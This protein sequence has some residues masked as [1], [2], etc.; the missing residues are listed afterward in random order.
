MIFSL[1]NAKD[2]NPLHFRPLAVLARVSN[3][4]TCFETQLLSNHN[5]HTP[6]QIPLN[7]IPFGVGRSKLVR[8]VFIYFQTILCQ[9]QLNPLLAESSQAISTGSWHALSLRRDRKLTVRFPADWSSFPGW[10][11]VPNWAQPSAADYRSHCPASPVPPRSLR[12]A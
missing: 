6:K 5:P 12:D 1:Y 3:Q 7:P 9:L 2:Y 10:K 11:S 4:P 8:F